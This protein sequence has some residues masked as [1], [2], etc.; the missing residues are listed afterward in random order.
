M[1]LINLPD[2]VSG[3]G[4]VAEAL[5]AL[6][7]RRRVSVA[8]WTRA[9]RYVRGAHAGLWNPDIAPYLEEPMEAFDTDGVEEIALVGPGRCGKTTVAESVLLKTIKADSAPIGWYANTD[10]VV[11]SYVK[12]TVNPLLDDHEAARAGGTLDDSL[13][14]KRFLRGTAV[15]FLAA[16][17]ANFR[18]KTFRYVIG[19]EFDGYDPALGDARGLLN[20]RRATEG[21]LGRTL[22]VSHPDRAEGNTPTDWRRGIMAIYA[23]STRCTWWWACPH[24][25]AYSSPNPG[26]V[27]HMAIVYPADAAL[28]TIAA[29]ARLL[30]P[31]N[32]CLIE[33]RSRTAMNRTGRWIGAGQAIDQDGTI[34]GMRM[35]NSVAGYWIVGAM[36]PF[37][38]AGIGGLAAA[39][40]EAERAV[41]A[42][43][44]GADVTLRQVLTK[45]WGIPNQPPVAKGNAIDAA[46]LAARAETLPIG[47]VP[48]GVRFLTAFLDIQ[49][50]RFELLVRGWGDGGESWII[51]HQAIQGEPATAPDDWDAAIRA[52]LHGAYPLADGSGRVMKVRGAG[53][54]SGGAPGVTEQ[55]YAAWKRF[56][57]TGHARRLGVI[58]A[59]DAWNLLPTK[60]MSTMG[61]YRLTVDYPD[62]VRKDRKTAAKGEIP[63]GKFNAN[64]FK[65]ALAG[66]LAVA[67]P[68][69]NYIHLP[70]WMTPDHFGQMVAETRKANGAWE[71][72]AKANEWLDLLVG[73]H[74]IAHLHGLNRLNWANPPGWAADWATNTAVGLPDARPA[75]VAV[76]RA[77]MPAPMPGLPPPLPP[78]AR[79]FAINRSG[80]RVL[81]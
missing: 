79:G 41:E 33:D 57:N 80:G 23:A 34:T 37:L 51:D 43:D 50:N 15:E 64:Q 20:M 78:A 62:T 69:R 68:G 44:D 3:Y 76:P 74:V 19:D 54:D 72:V 56:R 28:E 63:L 17:D 42:G 29:E 2:Y 31:V 47:V 26:T 49:A 48:A 21:R 75:P 67:M 11:K 38:L 14:F 70:D 77:A 81:A 16:S 39:R 65:D 73:T 22:F 8:E 59:R 53:Y 9:S 55:A 12:T 10:D 71:K 61:A 5:D 58:G 66:Q 30:C 52:A 32:G 36:S 4:L 25:G 60:G 40:V 6:L 13:S 24:C 35:P 45:Q 27:R 1:P 18:N 46:T 7:P